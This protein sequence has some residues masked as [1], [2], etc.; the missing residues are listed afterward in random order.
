MNK[1]GTYL[2]A[3]LDYKSISIEEFSNMINY[4]SSYIKDI[5]DSKVMITDDIITKISNSTGI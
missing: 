5:I 3:Y 4:D 2:K 1:F